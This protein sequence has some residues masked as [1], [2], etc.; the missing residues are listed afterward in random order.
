M[1]VGPVGAAGTYVG[2]ARARPGSIVVDRP[3]PP[4]QPPPQ[5]RRRQRPAALLLSLRLH[6]RPHAAGR[7]HPAR[8]A[9]DGPG[10]AVPLPLRPGGGGARHGARA[11]GVPAARRVG[12]KRRRR[13]GGRAAAVCG[14]AEPAVRLR[15]RGAAGCGLAAAD[16]GGARADA[17]RGGGAECECAGGGGR[18]RVSG[19]SI[20]AGGE[21]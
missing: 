9:R 18:K 20:S 7:Q 14:G 16:G 1:G 4:I 21:V 19:V 6:P 5:K 11:G 13:R 2:G 15:E 3:T 10:G 12:R 17:P 8:R